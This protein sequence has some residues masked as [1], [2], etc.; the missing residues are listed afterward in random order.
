MNEF[1]DW[2]LLAT[3]GGACL[4]TNLIVAVVKYI[5]PK[6][7]STALRLI[8]LGLSLGLV[9]IIQVVAVGDYSLQTIVLAV[10]NGFVVFAETQG[11]YFLAT[12]GKT[13]IK[14]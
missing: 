5:F 7:G 3:F 8:A 14:G 13:S 12:E 6:I 9:F 4:A 2:S 1:F 11:V 10:F